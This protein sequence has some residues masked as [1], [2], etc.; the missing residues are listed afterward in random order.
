MFYIDLNWT[1]SKYV[2]AKDLAYFMDLHE[3][4]LIIFGC[5]VWF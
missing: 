2:G 5:A 1:F 4:N 3:Q